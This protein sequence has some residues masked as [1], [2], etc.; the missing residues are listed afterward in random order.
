MNLNKD[1]GNISYPYKGES[2]RRININNPTQENV[3]QPRDKL[4][5]LIIPNYKIIERIEK[6]EGIEKDKEFKF[7]DFHQYLKKNYPEYVDLSQKPIEFFDK[8]NGFPVYFHETASFFGKYSS[9]YILKLLYAYRGAIANRYPF[10]IDSI[11][12][13]GERVTSKGE[14]ELLVDTQERNKQNRRVV[15]TGYKLEERN[16][17]STVDVAK[18]DF[19]YFRM[20]LLGEVSGYA[21]ANVL[22]SADI[23]VGV[24]TEALLIKGSRKCEK[25]KVHDIKR[26]EI[27]TKNKK[28]KDKEDSDPL[29]EAKASGKGGAFV[30]VKA[31]AGLKAALQWNS[32]IIE[33]DDCKELGNVGVAVNGTAGAEL[34][35]EFK[36]G[37]DSTSGRFTIKASASAALG[38]GGGGTAEFSVGLGG[39]YELVMY[40]YNQLKDNDFNFV[41]LFE[42]TR[43]GYNVYQIFVAWQVQLLQEGVDLAKDA[44][45]A[46]EGFASDITIKAQVLL[47]DARK[48]VADWHAAEQKEGQIKNLLSM[49]KDG[50]KNKGFMNFLTPEV[51]GRILYY[52]AKHRISYWEDIK[53]FDKNH[54]SETA[55]LKILEEYIVSKRDW[56]E[57][58]EHMV[59]DARKDENSSQ[60]YTRIK[61]KRKNKSF[62][63]MERD[64]LLLT[65]NENWLK[66]YLLKD[67]EDWKRVVEIRK[68]LWKKEE[69]K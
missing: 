22:L 64:V 58:F 19:G 16:T 46:I 30:G 15:L 6:I 66:T 26:K 57:T 14:S 35:G 54:G 31:E 33:K 21:G 48:L 27:S 56:Q 12:R 69:E 53:T 29:L 67:A 8:M 18:L 4:E 3:T 44:K 65:D 11:V 43:E 34:S 23:N 1:M 52:L 63:D 41:D 42:T 2:Q 10:I 51:K 25:E 47:S 68:E 28:T 39:L 38:A 13:H 50:K 62:D 20:D 59:V 60:P 32:V 37:Y 45:K 61:S 40:V 17:F 5:E 49:I 7:S 55:A 36:I 9:E 24:N